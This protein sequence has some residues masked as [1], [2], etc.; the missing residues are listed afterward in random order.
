M[1]RSA[2]TDGPRVGTSS[3]L[4][5]SVLR[6]H[7]T[8][9]RPHEHLLLTLALVLFRERTH[10]ADDL[11]HAFELGLRHEHKMMLLHHARRLH[12]G[13]ARLLFVIGLRELDE[14][15][16]FFQHVVACGHGRPPEVSQWGTCTISNKTREHT[17][18]FTA[19]RSP[20]RSVSLRSAYVRIIWSGRSA[21]A[22]RALRW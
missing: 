15:S 22:R 1:M 19:E 7:E 21:P 6:G 14:V 5:E 2:P 3:S 12:R 16:D 10:V 17:T 11:L 4:N 18:C 9:K 20:S 8:E 13:G